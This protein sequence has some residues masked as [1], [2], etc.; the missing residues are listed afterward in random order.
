VIKFTSFYRLKLLGRSVCVCVLLFIWVENKEGKE[1]VRRKKNSWSMP[2]C[3]YAV[4]A[5][6]K[7]K[8]K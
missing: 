2:F 3:S 5:V 1:F 6:I 7:K 4:K 8:M